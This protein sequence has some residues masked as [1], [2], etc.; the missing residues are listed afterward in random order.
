MTEKTQ[1]PSLASIEADLFGT[2][3]GFHEKTMALVRQSSLDDEKLR[4]VADRMNSLL[5]SVT[6]EIKE[7]K[8]FNLTDRLE[9]AYSE[10]KRLI[11]E[12]SAGKNG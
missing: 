4:I 10:V 1:K 12:V 3:F 9:A 5:D 8:E 7:R 11:D 2:L 6:A